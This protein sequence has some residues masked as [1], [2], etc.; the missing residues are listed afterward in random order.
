[1]PNFKIAYDSLLSLSNLQLRQYSD[2]KIELKRSL[3]RTKTLLKLLG[4]PEEKL[5]FVHITGTSG[6]GSVANM[7][8][9]ILVAD[10]RKVGTYTSPHLTSY[11][12]RFQI[13]DKFIDPELLARC[14]LDVINA[15]SRLLGKGESE[16]SFFELSTVLALYA[17]HEAGCKWCVLEVGCGGRYDATNIIPTPKIAII[18]NVDKDH[19]EILGDSLSKIAY[20][21][22]GIIKNKGFVLC[23]ESR[24][25][26]RKIFMKEAIQTQAALFFIN[27]PTSEIIDGKFGLH[28]QHNAALAERAAFELGVDPH[29]IASTLKNFKK[30]ACRFETV[31]NNPLLI[32]DGAHSP[33]KIKAAVRMIKKLNQPVHILFGCTATKDAQELID[34]LNEV[35]KT[36]TTTRFTTTFRKASNPARLLSFVQKSKRAGFFLDPQ[37]ALEHIRKL[38][39]NGEAI[40]VTGSLY[41]AGELRAEWVSESEILKK[42]SNS[43]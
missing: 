4:S 23:G 42:R 29:V 16:L 28:Q 24:P 6:K 35:A 32:L 17:F 25:A 34:Q 15:Y 1:M 33:A 19:T 5:K 2:S 21:K 41:L 10:D 13:N 37:E 40:V 43:L 14:I 20:E 18:T 9:Q 27:Q 8:H 26:L 7:M 11:L 31:Q 22:A 3:A 36:I 12:E 38:T 30:P 39:K